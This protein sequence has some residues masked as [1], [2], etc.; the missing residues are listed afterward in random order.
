M[1]MENGEE[2][3]DRSAMKLLGDGVKWFCR[4]LQDGADIQM[5]TR[6]W[7]KPADRIGIWGHEESK[8]AR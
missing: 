1:L 4:G 2:L 7:S 8:A 6:A 5:G 3:H